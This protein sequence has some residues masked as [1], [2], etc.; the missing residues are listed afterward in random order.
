V[1]RIRSEILAGRIT[2]I[3]QDNVLDRKAKVHFSIITKMASVFNTAFA[4]K[5][6]YFFLGG[7]SFIIFSLS[8]VS[9]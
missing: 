3:M 5:T 6:N 8:L 4:D 2:S 7:R 9:P 1:A